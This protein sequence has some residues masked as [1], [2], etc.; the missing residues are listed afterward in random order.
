MG[1]QLLIFLIDAVFG[2]FVFM[3]LARFYMQL[4]RVSFRN[5]FGQFVIAIT[6]WCVQPARRIIPGLG[7]ID[8]PTLVMAILFQGVLI[9]LTMASKGV[10]PGVGSI[11]GIVLMAVLELIKTSVWLLIIV[12]IGAAILSWVSPHSPVAPTLNGI[13]APFLRPLQKVIPPIAGVDLSPLVLLLILQVVLMLLDSAR[14]TV[15]P[16]ML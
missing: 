13:A 7:G 6:D 12:V 15:F 11:I 5:Q 16:L 10:M 14:A 9:A 2:F 8:L 1:T 3:L 4:A